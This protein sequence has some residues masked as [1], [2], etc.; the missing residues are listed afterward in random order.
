MRSDKSGHLSAC[1]LPSAFSVVRLSQALERVSVI[2]PVRR[3]F[4]IDPA[5]LL[6]EQ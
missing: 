2:N 3:A 4:H 1:G 5:N 6:R